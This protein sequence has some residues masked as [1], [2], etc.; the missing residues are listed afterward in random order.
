MILRMDMS[1]H[2]AYEGELHDREGVKPE[3]L[4]MI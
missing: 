2:L 3:F 4:G 1:L